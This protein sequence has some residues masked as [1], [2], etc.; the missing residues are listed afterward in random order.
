M[1]TALP[2]NGE[3]M[4]LVPKRNC[5]GAKTRLLGNPVQETRC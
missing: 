2:R 5:F 3:F 1:F 4:K